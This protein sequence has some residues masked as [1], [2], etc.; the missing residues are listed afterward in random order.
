MAGYNFKLNDVQKL[1]WLTSNEFILEN[2]LRRVH[3]NWGG[4]RIKY[5]NAHFLAHFLGS[6]EH[7]IFEAQSLIQLFSN[8][9]EKVIESIDKI[10]ILHGKII[11]LINYKGFK[12]RRLKDLLSY[13]CIKAVDDIKRFLKPKIISLMMI[14]S[15][16]ANKRYIK[17]KSIILKGLHCIIKECTTMCNSP[18]EN[19]TVEK[20]VKIN[21]KNTRLLNVKYN[22]SGSL[23]NPLCSIKLAYSLCHFIL[24]V[25][26]SMGVNYIYSAGMIRKPKRAC[27]L[28]HPKGLAIDIKGFSIRSSNDADKSVFLLRGGYPAVRIS[29]DSDGNYMVTPYKMKRNRNTSDWFYIK[30]YYEMQKSIESERI[31][32]INLGISLL[33]HTGVNLKMLEFGNKL[34]KY[35]PFVIGPGHN[36]SHMNHFHAQVEGNKFSMPATIYNPT[37]FKK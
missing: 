28:C 37:P 9:L 32:S 5:E 20:A 29:F 15:E 24:D 11:K 31:E 10:K 17:F 19:Y 23:I 2:D 14:Q 36:K 12:S 33:E 7:L 35:F 21:F 34:G 26:N 18:N 6:F 25:K 30:E 1:K 4:G 22:P 3:E 16:R 13:R 27:D 8:P